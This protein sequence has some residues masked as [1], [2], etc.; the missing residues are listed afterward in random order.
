MEQAMEHS[1]SQW[2]DSLFW[3]WSLGW[4]GNVV[5][6][7]HFAIKN[8]LLATAGVMLVRDITYTFVYN[9]L[10][11]VKIFFEGQRGFDEIERI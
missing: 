1:I 3:K 10:V 6:G 5:N 4:N 2:L 9:Y 11:E 7:S 8:H